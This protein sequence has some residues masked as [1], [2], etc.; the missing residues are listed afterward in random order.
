MI[1]AGSPLIT[2]QLLL[3]SIEAIEY[4]TGS[5]FK[6]EAIHELRHSSINDYLDKIINLQAGNDKDK[7]ANISYYRCHT[8]KMINACSHFNRKLLERICDVLTLSYE[9]LIAE[10]TE[11]K[12]KLSLLECYIN[13]IEKTPLTFLH[14]LKKNSYS[15]KKE[16]TTLTLSLI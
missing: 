11:Q 16:L 3:D 4:H 7:C 14:T 9:D 15:H 1:S 2:Y 6:D 8:F 10:I 5:E 12:A 13:I